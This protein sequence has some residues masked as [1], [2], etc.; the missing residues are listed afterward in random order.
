VLKDRQAVYDAAAARREALADIARKTRVA[1][2]KHSQD[3]R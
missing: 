1:A 3:D 2:Q